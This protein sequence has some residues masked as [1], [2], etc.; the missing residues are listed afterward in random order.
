MKTFNENLDWNEILKESKNYKYVVML[1]DHYNGNG[2]GEFFESQHFDWLMEHQKFWFFNCERP[3]YH[4][5]LTNDNVPAIIDKRKT[6]INAINDIER[7]LREIVIPMRPACDGRA[8]RRTQP[9]AYAQWDKDREDGKTKY[10][11][12]KSKHDSLLN[13]LS[14]IK[15]SFSTTLLELKPN[16]D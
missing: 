6:L 16:N 11:I 2:K 12:L 3:V 4:V 9:E 14:S 5:T 10:S 15:P 13:E 1:R 7:K 8:T